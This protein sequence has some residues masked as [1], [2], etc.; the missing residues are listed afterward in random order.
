MHLE[1]VEP[2]TRYAD[3]VL[4]EGFNPVGVDLVVE[5]IKAMIPEEGRRQKAKGQ[6]QK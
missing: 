4:P 3:L 1:I 6:G 5:K 2:S